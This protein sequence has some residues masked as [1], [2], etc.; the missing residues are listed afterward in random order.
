MRQK[1]AI[2]GVVLLSFGAV[3][4]PHNEPFEKL[5]QYG[6]FKGE[7]KNLDPS[8]N[9]IAYELNTPLFTDYA[10]K[11]RFM[12][13]PAGKATMESNFKLSF[14]VGTTLIKNF[15]YPEDF[16]KETGKRRILETRLLIHK[17][18]GWEALTY[19]WN[20]EQTDAELEYAGDELEIKWTHH[21]GKERTASYVVP[22]KNQCKGC[23]ET[24]KKVVPIGP[25][26]RNL[27]RKNKY[28]G[29]EVN[30]LEYLHSTGQLDLGAASIASVP[31]F[32][33]WDDAKNWSIND[34]ARAWL[35]VNCAHCHNPAGPANTSGLD[36]A[37]DQNDP[38]KI[39]IC[40][41]PI[42]AGRGSGGLHFDILPGK[43]EHSILHYRL[44]T[45]DPGVM[46]PE[47]GRTMIHEEGVKLVAEWISG[48]TEP[49]CKK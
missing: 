38:G 46:M 3:S 36:L 25:T 34:R 24:S 13:I 26:A 11:A 18:E 40:K 43:P 48:M 9:V 5:S 49:D 31:V 21:D 17:P 2:L 45:N 12:H 35:D 42:A 30:Q 10:Y 47:L 41:V 28:F 19:V 14:P 29:K 8:G 7:L 6:F 20:A 4:Q 23:H 33:V 22:N 1:W 16:R 27:N 39:G 44:I 15:Y 32:P 37:F